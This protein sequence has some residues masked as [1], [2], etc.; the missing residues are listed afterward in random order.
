ML[1]L[2]CTRP[3]CSTPLTFPRF[4]SWRRCERTTKTVVS[5]LLLEIPMAR[6]AGK[7]RAFTCAT[8]SLW[9]AR[10]EVRHMSTQQVYVAAH[11]WLRSRPP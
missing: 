2:C 7:Q 8:V 10:V 3:R 1:S 9:N 6:T 11:T 4:G 5:D